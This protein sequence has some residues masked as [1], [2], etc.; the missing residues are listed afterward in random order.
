MPADADADA[1][2][3]SYVNPHISTSDPFLSPRSTPL[4]DNSKSDPS[5]S[6][7]SWPDLTLEEIIQAVPDK[8]TAPGGDGVDWTIIQRALDQIPIYFFLSYTFLLQYGHHPLIWKTSVGIVI[9]KRGKPDYSAPKAYRP[10][11]LIPCLSK[12]LERIF[13]KRISYLDHTSPNLLHPS[14]MRGRKQR[15]CMT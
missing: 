13:A 14:Q 6:P 11:S 15:S 7:W 9:P 10:I 12:L 8:K 5:S 3:F 4:P 2:P 1:L